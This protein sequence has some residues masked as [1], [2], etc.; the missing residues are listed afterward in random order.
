[1]LLYHQFVPAGTK[2]SPKLQWTMQA[3]V[4]ES[5]MKYIHDNGYHVVPMS[6]VLAFIKPPDHAAR[7][8]GLHHLR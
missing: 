3:D 7:R 5:E 1:M 6:D 8:L 2:L 4:F